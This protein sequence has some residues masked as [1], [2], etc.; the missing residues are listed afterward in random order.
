MAFFPDE[1]ATWGHLL[2]IPI[3][4]VPTVWDLDAATAEQL[5]E[6]CR[7]LAT[8]LTDAVGAE[9]LN[10]IQSNGVIAEQSVFHLHVHLVPRTQGDAIGRIWPSDQ[11]SEGE[12]DVMW[13][14]VGRKLREQL[15][16]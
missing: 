14:E 8:P 9:G 15:G 10:L 13:V 16:P 3:A 4:H 7:R 1:P 12:K 11:F 6:M 2:V 5:A